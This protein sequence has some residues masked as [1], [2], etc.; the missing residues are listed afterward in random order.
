MVAEVRD[1][2]VSPLKQPKAVAIALPQAVLSSRAPLRRSSIHRIHGLPKGVGFELSE[3][4][5]EWGVSVST[6]QGHACS[7]KCLRYLE[8]AGEWIQVVMHPETAKQHS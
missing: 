7:L 5:L 2:M 6:I 1:A 3:L 8:V 4:A